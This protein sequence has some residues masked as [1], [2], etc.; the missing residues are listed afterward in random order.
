M[1]EQAD[2]QHG[3]FP[4]VFADL[5][6]DSFRAPDFKA[7]FAEFCNKL[8]AYLVGKLLQVSTCRFQY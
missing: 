6:P 8:R 4:Q 5:G 7:V 2:G 1:Q 3:L